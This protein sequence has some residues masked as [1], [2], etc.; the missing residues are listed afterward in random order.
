[1]ALICVFT[2]RLSLLLLSSSEVNGAHQF[3]HHPR[4]EPGIYPKLSHFPLPL[5]L[6]PRNL[7]DRT[8][9][10]PHIRHWPLKGIQVS[11]QRTDDSS[12][13]SSLDKVG[14]NH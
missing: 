8:W 3:S 5:C 12:E 6:I 4:Q 14:V 7:T 1:M 10:M 13:R 2:L 9:E 11:V